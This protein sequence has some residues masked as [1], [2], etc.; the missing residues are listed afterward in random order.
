MQYN[1]CGKFPTNHIL[2]TKKVIPPNEE[3]FAIE[4][5]TNEMAITEYEIQ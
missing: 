2:F 4:K 1:H 5:R 3:L